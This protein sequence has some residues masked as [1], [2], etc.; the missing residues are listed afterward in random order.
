MPGIGRRLPDRRI[1]EAKDRDRRRTF[2]PMLK[3]VVRRRYDNRIVWL[4]DRSGRS[5]AHVVNALRR[6]IAASRTSLVP[7]AGSS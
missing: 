2:D 3:D 1:G 6:C 4:I 7:T 5:V